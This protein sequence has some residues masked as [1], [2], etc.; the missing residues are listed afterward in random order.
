MVTRKTKMTL[1][2]LVMLLALIG[3]KS[4]TIRKAII[5]DGLVAHYPF[6]GS[7]A[8]LG[9]NNLHGKVHGATLTTDRKGESNAAYLFDGTNDYISVRHNDLLNLTGDFSIS[10]WTQIALA[11]APE[12]NINDILRKWNG[13]H[14]GYPFSISYINSTA[15]SDVAD[16]IFYVRYDGHTCVNTPQGYSGSITNDVFIHIV[17]IR[18][19]TTLSNYL[20]GVLV[21]EFDDTTSCGTS[22]TANMT[23]GCRGNLV[24]FFKGKIDD[25]RI[26]N[27]SLSTDEIALLFAE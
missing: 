16:K 9:G 7:A 18:K 23:I 12:A 4:V 3:C 5:T 11:Q 17:F 14:T 27:R 26:Y 21:S 6:N 24:R 15:L 8:D 13:D 10:L 22:N 25:I 2:L 1:L 20:N 19:G